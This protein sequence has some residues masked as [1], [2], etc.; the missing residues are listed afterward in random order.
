GGLA[1]F[2]PGHNGPQ[3]WRWMGPV[4][5]NPPNPR[6]ATAF[7]ALG[8]ING[9]ETIGVV[10]AMTD[11]EDVNDI[12]AAFQFRRVI[13]TNM[14]RTRRL[15]AALA[16]SLSGARLAHVTYGPRPED[17]LQILEAGALAA[18]MMDA[19]AH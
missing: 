9:V 17:G 6:P 11:A 12:I 3:L 4:A 10:S 16:A 14:D 18:Q 19:S 1:W 2:P 15:G 5:F 7:R 8:D 13:I